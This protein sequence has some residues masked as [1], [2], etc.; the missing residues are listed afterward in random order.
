MNL[1]S[2]EKLSFGHAR[3]KCVDLKE[4]HAISG[5]MEAIPV[6]KALEEKNIPCLHIETDCSMED[7]G[8]LENTHRSICRAG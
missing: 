8:Q 3:R 5:L 4:Y 6:E 2:L 7:V 1:S